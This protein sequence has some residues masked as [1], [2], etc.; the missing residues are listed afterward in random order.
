MPTA[1][2]TATAVVEQGDD[3]ELR[4]AAL[5]NLATAQ[6]MVQRGKE[7]LD[8]AG[9]RSGTDPNTMVHKKYPVTTHTK[10]IEYRRHGTNVS[11]F[12]RN[13]LVQ[14]RWRLCLAYH[15]ARRYFGKSRCYETKSGR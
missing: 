9:Q 7:L 8:H 12:Q 5:F 10:T 11:K 14:I 13:P 3:A 4:P 6:H 2:P 15:L 1:T